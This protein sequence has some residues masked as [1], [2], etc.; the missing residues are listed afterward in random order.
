MKIGKLSTEHDGSIVAMGQVVG[1]IAPD[2][3][4]PQQVRNFNKELVRRWNAFE[5][6]TE[7]KDSEVVAQKMAN[8]IIAGHGG[9]DDVYD[10]ELLENACHHA[11][12]YVGGGEVAKEIIRTERN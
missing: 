4:T 1:N 12:Q 9:Q 8:A 2:I 3:L 6:T 7:L 11:V 10:Y 5:G